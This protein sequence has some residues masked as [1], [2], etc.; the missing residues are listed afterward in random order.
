MEV[1]LIESLAMNPPP[2][3]RC[4]AQD[5]HRDCLGHCGSQIGDELCGKA[6]CT[7]CQGEYALLFLLLPEVAN[8]VP[9]EGPSKNGNISVTVFLSIENHLSTQS[10]EIR[11]AFYLEDAGE[12]CSATVSTLCSY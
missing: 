7:R 6:G 11:H 10:I 5:G 8:D 4:S 12:V 9:T 1:V 3:S 2:R